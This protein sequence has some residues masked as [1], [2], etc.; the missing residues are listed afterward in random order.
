MNILLTDQL[1][2]S[3]KM[4]LLNIKAASELLIPECKLEKTIDIANFQV[5]RK[6]TD[7]KQTMVNSVFDALKSLF[8][9]ENYLRTMQNTDMGFMIGITLLF[10][11]TFL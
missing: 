1:S 8:T 10:Q 11:K 6:Y 5:V 9:S 4:K 2:Y 3:T 7:S